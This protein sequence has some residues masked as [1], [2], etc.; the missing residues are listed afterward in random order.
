MRKG[1]V[2]RN[3]LRWKL[4]L[5][6]GAILLLIAAIFLRQREREKA[7]EEYEASIKQ[8]SK[9]KNQ[10]EELKGEFGEGQETEDRFQDAEKTTG[11]PDQKSEETVM[12]HI[13]NLEEYAA[14]LMGDDTRLLEKS[15]GEW[16][17][18]KHLDAE[19]A[20]ILNVM[21]PESDPQSI[22]F[23]IRMDD[24]DGSLV[25]LSYQPREKVV[26]A[27][28]CDYTE[29]EILAEA[30]EGN[31]PGQRDVTAEEDT[32]FLNNQE[33]MNDTEGEN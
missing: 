4:L 1:N 5:L 11:F 21:I 16:I 20:A 2:Y 25:L 27:S 17:M 28:A 22:H 6:F 15:L 32:E 19:S 12:V 24:G 3:K 23:Y 9:V 7:K 8:E 13:R 30:W 31:G 10:E 29:E 14:D 26:T 18:E 33:E